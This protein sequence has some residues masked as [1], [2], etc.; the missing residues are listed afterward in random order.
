M[1]SAMDGGSLETTDELNIAAA[2]SAEAAVDPI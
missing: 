2:G 1:L